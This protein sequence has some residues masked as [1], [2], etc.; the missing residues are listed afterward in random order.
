MR[1]LAW[2]E[3]ARWTQ[4]HIDHLG[5]PLCGTPV[6]EHPWAMA[7]KAATPSD[8]PLICAKCRTLATQVATGAGGYC[9]CNHRQAAHDGGFGPCSACRCTTFE[10]DPIYEPEA[11][12][13]A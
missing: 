8:W 7:Y 3:N 11:S 6:P 9:L 4:W 1:I 10:H 12:S 13:H 5:Q 2:R